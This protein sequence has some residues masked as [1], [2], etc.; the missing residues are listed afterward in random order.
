MSNTRVSL[1]IIAQGP[2]TPPHSRS[3]S[4]PPQPD[5]V[6]SPL[7]SARLPLH[8]P[9]IARFDDFFPVS[10][11][12]RMTTVVPTPPPY[13]RARAEM[14]AP[15]YG[16]EQEAPT[17]AKFFFRYGFGTLNSVVSVGRLTKIILASL[18]GILVDRRDDSLHALA[19]LPGSGMRQNCRRASRRNGDSPSNGV[20]LGE[21]V[22]RSIPN[23]ARSGGCSYCRS[24]SLESDALDP[25]KFSV[26]LNVL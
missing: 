21:E 11:A 15:A 4:Y 10:P 8:Q 3:A 5:F 13:T 19:A 1:P 14:P 22:R 23:A 6:L 18:S 2:N 12:S 26:S 16:E 20:I 25:E 24:G 9:F 7:P 17:L